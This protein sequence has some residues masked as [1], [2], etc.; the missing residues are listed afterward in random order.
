MNLLSD[1][2]LKDEHTEK[3]VNILKLIFSKDTLTGQKSIVFVKI[4]PLIQF[5]GFFKNKLI[6]HYNFS[7]L[8]KIL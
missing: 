8:F 4:M 3:K 7:L 5:I 6:V 1:D 2:S